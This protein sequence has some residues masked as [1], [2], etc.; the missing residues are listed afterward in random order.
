MTDDSLQI[1][2]EE[3]EDLLSVAEQALL[4]LDDIKNTWV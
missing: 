1:F 2:A 4:N 3:A